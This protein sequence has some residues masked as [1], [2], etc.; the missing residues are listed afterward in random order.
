MSQL[1]N[2]ILAPFVEKLRGRGN[3]DRADCT[4][5]LDL[6]YRI[7]PLRRHEFIVREDEMAREC[8]VLL[9]GIAMRHK[10]AG[11]GL[12]QIFSI[13]MRG[14]AVDLHNSLLGRAD[15]NLEMLSNGEGAFVP[16]EAINVL[17]M[18]RPRVAQ[19]MW[20]ETLVD[21]SIFREW[22]L[23]IGRRD[24][25]SRMAHVLCEF[26]IRL[27][28]VGLTE[29][30]GY[31]LPMTQEELGDALAL[32]SIH[33]S[34]TLKALE[35]ENLV[36]RSRRSVKILDW[37]RLAKI[38]DFDAGYLHLPEGARAISIAH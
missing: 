23:N 5:I 21:A 3:L 19:A 26:A 6:P 31:E 29:A 18:S 4:A 1:H 37:H 22:T 8:C 38:G 2:S 11:N 32:T 24:A 35:A 34:R 30:T 17:T 27:E 16:I 10:V 13:H 20:R 25:R 15:H 7:S 9:S 33:V 14:D 36:S 28:L 12:R